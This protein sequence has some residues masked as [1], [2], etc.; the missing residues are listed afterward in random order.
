MGAAEESAKYEKQSRMAALLCYCEPVSFGDFV[1]PRETAALM[2]YYLADDVTRSMSSSI[3]Q[4]MR[5]DAELGLQ[6]LMRAYRVADS[7]FAD[8]FD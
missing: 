3:T 8:L 6:K 2:A 5:A 1:T 7:E 4:D